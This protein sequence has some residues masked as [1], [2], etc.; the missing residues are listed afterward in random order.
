MNCYVHNWKD[1]TSY[2][3]LAGVVVETLHLGF[4]GEADSDELGIEE[5]YY[6]KEGRTWNRQPRRQATFNC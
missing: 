1:G 6:V 4:V 5:V 2:A 3:L